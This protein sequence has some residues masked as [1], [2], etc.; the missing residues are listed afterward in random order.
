[1]DW[2]SRRCRSWAV[3]FFVAGSSLGTNANNTFQQVNTLG[4]VSAPVA[5]R[6]ITTVAKAIEAVGG[7]DAGDKP[8]NPQEG[9]ACRGKGTRPISKIMIVNRA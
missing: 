8:Q 7:N 9:T 6:T 4:G 5:Y 2:P 3:V 1:M